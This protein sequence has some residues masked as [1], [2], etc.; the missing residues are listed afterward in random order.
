M[1]TPTLI[2]I[3]GFP[4]SG[5]STHASEHYPDF[6]HY[7]PDHFFC[8]SAGRYRFDAQLWTQACEWTQA[9]TDFA[10]ARGE[11]VVVTDVFP[12]LS[13]LDPY[14]NLAAAHGADMRVITLL[15]THGNTHRVPVYVLARMAREFEYETWQVPTINRRE[16]DGREVLP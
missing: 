2:I 15:G 6:L 14:R 5:K 7:E 9:L 13:D 8:D 10:L 12:R 1:T 11:S 4:G 3:R 16:G